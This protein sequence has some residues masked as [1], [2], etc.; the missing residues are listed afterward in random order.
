M[1][2]V[3][4]VGLGPQGRVR[5]EIATRIVDKQIAATGKH[6]LWGPPFYRNFGAMQIQHRCQRI[7]E[8]MIV[9]TATFDWHL[10]N[11]VEPIKVETQATLQTIIGSLVIA[12]FC[13]SALHAF[14]VI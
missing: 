7:R 13:V 2:S 10:A 4:T 3:I 8:A 11:V 1:D 12:F 14:G 5:K 9:D 6:F